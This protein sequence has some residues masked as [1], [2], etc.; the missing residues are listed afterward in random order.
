MFPHVDTRAGSNDLLKAQSRIAWDQTSRKGSVPRNRLVHAMEGVVQL[1]HHFE[2]HAHKQ[3]NSSQ[4]QQPQSLLQLFVEHLYSNV[5][6]F[7]TYGRVCCFLFNTMSGIQTLIFK[8][9]TTPGS[10][11]YIEGFSGNGFICSAVIYSVFAVASW[12][13]P[14]VVAFK[15]KYRI[16]L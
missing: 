12:F 10:G 3:R 8:S 14:S 5:R 11:G 7:G 1:Y 4:P 2:E 6:C 16:R 15:G 13:S 9:A